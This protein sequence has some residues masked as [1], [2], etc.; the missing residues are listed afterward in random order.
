MVYRRRRSTGHFEDRRWSF[1]HFRNEQL[2]IFPPS[3]PTNVIF[4]LPWQR[5]STIVPVKRGG[6][7]TL[8]AK[9]STYSRSGEDFLTKKGWLFFYRANATV[10]RR[11][12]PP[13]GEDN[14]EL[15]RGWWFPKSLTTRSLVELFFER[16]AEQSFQNFPLLDRI[17]IFERNRWLFGC[18]SLILYLV[19]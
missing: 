17:L 14:L 16:V 12:R 6:K 8:W 19:Y 7:I 4:E 2:T 3:C 18:Q 5:V 13:F 11:P 15:Y 9:Y 1:V 10:H